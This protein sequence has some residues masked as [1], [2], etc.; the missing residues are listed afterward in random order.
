MEFGLSDTDGIQTDEKMRS[1]HSNH[2]QPGQDASLAD[3]NDCAEPAT[4]LSAKQCKCKEKEERMIDRR[5]RHAQ[6]LLE[7]RVHLGELQVL[8]VFGNLQPETWHWPQ[9]ETAHSGPTDT[10][11]SMSQSRCDR[12]LG[13][14]QLQR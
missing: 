5:Y 12:H 13:E 7:C 14:W 2:V 6:S 1:R 9:A 8:G 4:I 3:E 11:G 10:L